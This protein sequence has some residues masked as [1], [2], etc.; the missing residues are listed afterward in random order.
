VKQGIEENREAVAAAQRGFTPLEAA[1]AFGDT[2]LPPPQRPASAPASGRAARSIPLHKPRRSTAEEADI[3]RYV[4]KQLMLRAKEKQDA[5]DK[6][7]YEQL[8][9]ERKHLMY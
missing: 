1:S 4:Q 7:K 2:E 8:Q 5:I 3:D 6:K 9:K